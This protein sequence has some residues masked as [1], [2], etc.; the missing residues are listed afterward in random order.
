MSVNIPGMDPVLLCGGELQRNTSSLY[1]LG[2]GTPHHFEG[3][4]VGLT[5]L[6]GGAWVVSCAWLGCTWVV[7]GC[8]RSCWVIIIR[9][10]HSNKVAA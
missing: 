7:L 5:R 10:L 1:N 3:Q 9:L 4:V 8:I 2:K 6:L